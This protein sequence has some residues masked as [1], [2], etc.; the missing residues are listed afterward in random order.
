MGMTTSPDRSS[1]SFHIAPWHGHFQANDAIRESTCEG[2]GNRA[3]VARRWEYERRHRH[4]ERP[5]VTLRVSYQ[6]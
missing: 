4:Q 1:A 6:R 5:A 2:P 3:A